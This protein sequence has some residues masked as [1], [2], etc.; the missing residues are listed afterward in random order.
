MRHRLSPD[1]AQRLDR[2]LDIIGD[3]NPLDVALV[4]H[5]LMGVGLSYLSKDRQNDFVDGLE[6]SV[7]RMLKEFADAGPTGPEAIR[8]H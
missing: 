5:A 6:V 4:G 7:P 2:I 1:A 3:L 8:T